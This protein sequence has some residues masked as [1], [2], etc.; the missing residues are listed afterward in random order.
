MDGMSEIKMG[1]FTRGFYGSCLLLLVH[2]LAFGLDTC[3]NGEV[4]V[5]DLLSNES[6]ITFPDA[7]AEFGP[8]FPDDGLLGRIV[9]ADPP[10]GCSILKPPPSRFT[11]DTFGWIALILRSQNCNFIHKV[12]N[13]QLA[14]YSAAIIYN[15]NRSKEVNQMGGNGE[16]I[17]IPS[18]FVSNTA[19]VFLKSKYNFNKTDVVIKI[20]EY[21]PP[22]FEFLLWP[23]VLVLSICF[24]VGLVYLV[25]KMCKDHIKKKVNRLSSKH[26]KKIPV[27]KF[28]KGDYYDTCAIC[29]DEYEEGEKIRVLPCDH[30]YHTKCIDPWLTKNKK[31]CPVCKRRVIPGRDADSESSDSD[32]GGTAQ[33]TGSESTPLLRGNNSRPYVSRGQRRFPQRNIQSDG[34]DGNEN[35]LNIHTEGNSVTQ[36]RPNAPADSGHE[37]GAV[38]GA[39]ISDRSVHS[40]SAESSERRRDRKR[41]RT[42]RQ[43]GSN[44]GNEQVL[45]A[46]VE[47]PVEGATGSVVDETREE[48]RERRRKKKE[49]KKASKRSVTPNEGSDLADGT[50]GSQARSSEER[51]SQPDEIAE[52]LNAQTMERPEVRI[53]PLRGRRHELNEKCDPIHSLFSF[54]FVLLN[55]CFCFFLLFFFNM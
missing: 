34:T 9:P 12:L 35:T 15:D 3:V 55:T 16:D 36:T 47:E 29:L 53:P 42:Y 24:L 21:Y 26:L 27:R 41:K 43:V 50:G 40:R 45:P 28:K 1:F 17:Q 33:S 2:I 54:F 52:E 32:G 49:Q 19:G 44:Q 37:N 4:I 31:T 13:A 18:V 25:I 23:F 20:Y 38:G 39:G 7:T 8:N 30:V 10:E 48:R 14:N 46:T 5:I 11:N 51:E 22:S 6:I